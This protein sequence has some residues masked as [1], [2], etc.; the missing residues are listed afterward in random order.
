LLGLGPGVLDDRRQDDRVRL[1]A[2]NFL[3]EV[4]IEV[5]LRLADSALASN[6]RLLRSLLARVTARGSPRNS[7]L[8]I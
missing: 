8:D 6:C 4:A 3:A 5:R 1:E 2:L 7:T